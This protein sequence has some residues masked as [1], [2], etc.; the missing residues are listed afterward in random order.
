[1]LHDT[2]DL[3]AALD[4][5]IV[6]RKLPSTIH[7]T[8]LYVFPYGWV[9]MTLGYLMYILAMAMLWPMCLHSGYGLKVNIRPGKVLQ[10]IFQVEQFVKRVR[11][12]VEGADIDMTAGAASLSSPDSHMYMPLSS[13]TLE[14]SQV[15][16]ENED[17]PPTPAV[18]Y[19][20]MGK[21]AVKKVPDSALLGMLVVISTELL[22][23]EVSTKRSRLPSIIG[24]L[25]NSTLEELDTKL[26]ILSKLQWNMDPFLKSE[27]GNL[28]NTP[29]GVFE[30]FV[31]SEVLPWIDREG[32][33]FINRFISNPSQSQKLV[34]NAK[35]L[36]RLGFDVFY[37]KGDSPQLPSGGG[38]GSTRYNGV[39]K[40]IEAR[41]IEWNRI[42]REVSGI[43]L[44]NLRSQPTEAIDKFLVESVLPSVDQQISPILNNLLADPQQVIYW[45][46]ITVLLY[47]YVNLYRIDG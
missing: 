2:L 23:R 9:R 27:L 42:V 3:C 47:I 11:L 28:Q 35:A 34:D 12:V 4:Q 33:Q 37:Q 44:E 26:E 13:L 20:Q 5:V 46:C 18:L 21:R 6:L 15:L 22:Q 24:D 7:I 17:K 45:I 38:N 41:D 43:I 14:E 16:G 39:A 32:V 29:I 1:M 40:N 19:L 8:K 25:A 36:V 31:G 10:T 30:K